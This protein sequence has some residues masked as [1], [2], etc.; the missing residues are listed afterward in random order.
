MNILDHSNQISIVSNTLSEK[1]AS[2]QVKR[3][4]LW[5]MLI[6]KTLIVNIM[7]VLISLPHGVH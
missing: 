6:T 5:V 4:T 7:T 2:N 3:S 1:N